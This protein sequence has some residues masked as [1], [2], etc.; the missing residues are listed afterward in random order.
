MGLLQEAQPWGAGGGALPPQEGADPRQHSAGQRQ[1]SAPAK[2]HTAGGGVLRGGRRLRRVAG[3]RRVA[4]QLPVGAR[5]QE[6]L[7]AGSVAG[8]F[9][10]ESVDDLLAVGQRL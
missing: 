6:A 3:S 4:V 5:R 8:P 2:V 9:L 10:K 1:Q 7:F